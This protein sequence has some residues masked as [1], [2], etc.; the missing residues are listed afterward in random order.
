MHRRHRTL[1][2]IEQKN[3]NTIRR[4]YADCP[5]YFAGYKSISLAGPVAKSA[6]VPHVGGMN[7]AQRHI[8]MRVREPCSK[9]M[10]LPNEFLKGVAPIDA[11]LA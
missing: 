9:S 3:G 7:L 4:P 2:D 11:I 1:P 8:H 10:A 6:R 5:R